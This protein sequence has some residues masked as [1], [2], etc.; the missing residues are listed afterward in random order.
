VASLF[1]DT[2]GWA[3]WLEPSEPFHVVARKIVDDA[4]DNGEPLLTTGF[5]MSELVAVLT[6]PMRVPKVRQIQ[7]LNDLHRDPALTILHV[8]VTLEAEAWRLWEQRPDKAWS[9]VDCCSF[10]VMKRES[11]L[12]AVT[13]DHHF[14]QAGFIRLLK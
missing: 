4:L 12:R 10:V 6:R 13:T 3:C 7:L 2:S 8:D 9:I 14:E 5:V 1:V 11:V